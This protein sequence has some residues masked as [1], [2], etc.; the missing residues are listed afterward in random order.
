MKNRIL[1]LVFTLI[2]FNSFSQNLSLS[3]LLK[4]R[5]MSNG[6][7]KDYLTSKGWGFLQ[8]T[9]ETEEDYASSFFNY[10]QDAVIKYSYS[11]EGIELLSIGFRKKEKYSQYLAEI[12]KIGGALVDSKVEYGD[13]VEYYKN[14]ILTFKVVTRIS[15]NSFG[16]KSTSYSIIIS[17]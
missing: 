3:E 11:T 15:E 9:E 16:E 13:L 17:D 12:K 4:I 6:Q 8:G 5:E 1:L 14:A 2:T 10:G 7:V